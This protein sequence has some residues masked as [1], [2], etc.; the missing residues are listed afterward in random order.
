MPQSYH[1]N[2]P[3]KQQRR[4]KKIHQETILRPNK[5]HQFTILSCNVDGTLD[6]A[7][8]LVY[9]CRFFST[10]MKPWIL[11][12]FMRGVDPVVS[13]IA[14]LLESN[15]EITLEYINISAYSLLIHV[16]FVFS[17]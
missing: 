3:R 5:I 12:L 14:I 13:L 9:S 15:G 2:S 16:I 4:P 1:P 6:F 7:T 10:L 11:K 8:I 17:K